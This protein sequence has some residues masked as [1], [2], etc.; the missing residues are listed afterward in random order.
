[1]IF[2]M[3]FAKE[4]Q[5]LAKRNTETDAYSTENDIVQ[6]ALNQNPKHI[7]TII[8]LKKATAYTLTIANA[9]DTQFR[10]ETLFEIEHKMPFPPDFVC[11]FYATDSPTPDEIGAYRLDYYRVGFGGEYIQAEVDEKYFRIIHSVYVSGGPFG[12]TYPYNVTIDGASLRSYR[13]K[14]IILQRPNMGTLDY[15][16]V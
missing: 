6:A 9:N 11:Y 10:Q 13:V 4:G 1:M 2:G 3:K 16:A 7:D 8:P 12:M 14:Y 5:D 15:A